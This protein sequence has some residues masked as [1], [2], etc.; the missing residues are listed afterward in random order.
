MVGNYEYCH[1]NKLIKFDLEIIKLKTKTKLNGRGLMY[2]LT[3]NMFY[4]D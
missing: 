2:Y 1:I 3:C 4:S